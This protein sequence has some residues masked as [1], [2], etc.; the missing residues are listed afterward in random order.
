MRAYLAIAATAALLISHVALAQTANPKGNT[1]AV[2]APNSPP[3][4]SSV[5]LADRGAAYR[6]AGWKSFDPK[7][8]PYTAEQVR[9]EREMYR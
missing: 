1:P 6:K 4:R 8:T 5:R 7:A 2:N 3:D 9:K